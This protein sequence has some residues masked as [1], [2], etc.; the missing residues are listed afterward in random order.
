M[1]R[2]TKQ[3]S[4]GGK[5][6]FLR[7]IV[8]AEA[9]IGEDAA[10]RL[11]ATLID[12]VTEVRVRREVWEATSKPGPGEKGLRAKA[13]PTAA[14]STTEPVAPVIGAAST[15]SASVPFD[16]FAFSAVAIL[17]KKGKDALAA[18][19]AKIAT[20]EHLRALANAQHLA[21]DQALGDVVALRDALVTATE[22]RLAERR[23]AAG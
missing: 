1:A 3:L 14:P 6:K 9:G 16:P 7:A 5:D 21:I 20:A 13:K 18:E 15:V 12:A 11:T 17:T 22:R 8:A 10:E 2:T 19:F 4:G 23:A